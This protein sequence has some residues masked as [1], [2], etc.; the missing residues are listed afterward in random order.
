MCRR[1]APL[2]GSAG[3]PADHRR[4][5]AP[6]PAPANN[7]YAAIFKPPAGGATIRSI[8]VAARA[9]F[10]ISFN[11]GCFIELRRASDLWSTA[12]VLKS[13]GFAAPPL[14]SPAPPYVTVNVVWG[15]DPGEGDMALVVRAGNPNVPAIYYPVRPP[16]DPV[17]TPGSAPVGT[18]NFTFKS[19]V[20]LFNAPNNSP[21]QEAEMSNIPSLQ[22]RAIV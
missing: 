3:W 19:Q 15:I 4:P 20:W 6:A 13:V 8:T 12:G 10:G 11:V 5:A 22:V 7:K 21:S 9:G 17:G 1:G 14:A 2:L 18:F 16:G